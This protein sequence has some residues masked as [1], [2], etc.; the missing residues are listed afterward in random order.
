[1]PRDL[2]ELLADDNARARLTEN[3]IERLEAIVSEIEETCARL[4]SGPVPQTLLHGDFHSGNVAT[5]DSGLIIFD[6][7][8]ACICHPYFDLLTVVDNEY[9]PLTEEQ[10]ERY[11]SSY[12]DEWEAAGY[13]SAQ[14]LREA[15]DLALKLGP[16][17][18][19]ISY[20]RID[21]I[22]EQATRAEIGL[23]MAYFLRLML[24]RL[25]QPVTL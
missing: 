24:G 3:E 7:T 6:W 11:L 19:A 1:M 16:L 12:L 13:G 18:H 8:D 21:N 14:S 25:E 23:S 15:C 17:Y 10:R 4:Q 5:T 20:W 22:C 9:E 2:R